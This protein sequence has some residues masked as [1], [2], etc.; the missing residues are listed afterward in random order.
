MATED[1]SIKRRRGTEAALKATGQLIDGQAGFCSDKK[2]ILFKRPATWTNPGG[3]DEYDIDGIEADIVENSNSIA[4]NTESIE[5]NIGKIKTS[6]SDPTP[7]FS[8][9]KVVVGGILTKNIAPSDTF[10]EQLQLAALVS[11]DN[12]TI[13]GTGTTASKLT[14]LTVGYKLVSTE[15]EFLEFAASYNHPRLW[16]GQNIT[17]N[18][19]VALYIRAPIKKIID[20]PGTITFIGNSNYALC[21]LYG[22]TNS[23]SIESSFSTTAI[24]DFKCKTKITQFFSCFYS[25]FW[26]RLCD[27]TVKTAETLYE[28]MAKENAR[29]HFGFSDNGYFRV[30]PIDLLGIAYYEG[31]EGK[32]FF[33]LDVNKIIINESLSLSPTCKTIYSVE[34]NDII[35]TILSVGGTATGEFNQEFY[36]KVNIGCG[37]S[38]T[39]VYPDPFGVS[40]TAIFSCSGG[41]RKGFITVKQLGDGYV[42]PPSGL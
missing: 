41:Y 42:L 7:G 5:E 24:V 29:V 39:F 12:E 8:F 17:V 37:S 15:A 14:V 19:P 34:T 13:G 22:S 1:K 2:K 33:D 16:I 23:S 20:G 10:G 32:Q 27:S 26:F 6:L 31:S 9:N 40:T 18:L 35:I 3:I 25:E 30:V 36:F 11:S 28:I 4:E 38:V 21:C